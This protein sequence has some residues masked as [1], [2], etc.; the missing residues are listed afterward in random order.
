MYFSIWKDPNAIPFTTVEVEFC[1]D[2][3]ELL[4]EI[5]ERDYRV[6]NPANF[7]DEETDKVVLIIKGSACKLF[8]RDGEE[9]SDED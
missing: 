5:H 1:E 2:E 9:D 7:P 6:V 3:E 4:E 8:L